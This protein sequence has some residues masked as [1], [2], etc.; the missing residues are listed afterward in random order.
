MRGDVNL[1]LLCRR[2]PSPPFQSEQ[3]VEAELS[4]FGEL[5]LAP[6]P[7]LPHV[8]AALEDKKVVAAGDEVNAW[9][10]SGG[11]MAVGA[12]GEGGGAHLASMAT[13]G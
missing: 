5:P 6:R 9:G 11:Q 4:P 7:L 13:R 2:L 1:E 10:E 12:Q 3:R 8:D